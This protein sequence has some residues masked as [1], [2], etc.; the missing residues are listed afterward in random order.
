MSCNLSQQGE[1]GINSH[2]PKWLHTLR[3]DPRSIAFYML[4]VIHI[5]NIYD[6]TR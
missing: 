1:A 4:A 5:F 6:L 2:Q 3:K